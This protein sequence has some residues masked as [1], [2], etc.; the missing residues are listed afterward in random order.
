MCKSNRFPRSA[1]DHVAGEVHQALSALVKEAN[2]HASPVRADSEGGSVLGRRCLRIIQTYLDVSALVTSPLSYQLMRDVRFST[3]TPTRF[4]CLLSQF[5]SPCVSSPENEDLVEEIQENTSQQTNKTMS[6]QFVSNAL[7]VSDCAQELLLTPNS[8]KSIEVVPS[9]TIAQPRAGFEKK[10][11]KSV[12][13]EI[14]ISRTAFSD[15]ENTN[16]NGKK[17]HGKRCAE[18]ISEQENIDTIAIPKNGK[19]LKLKESDPITDD[20]SV[21]IA[22]KTMESPKSSKRSKIK[23][24]KSCRRRLLPQV[25]GQSK[26]T[27]FFKM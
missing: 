6:Q 4:P 21:I 14:S 2:K 5:K 27:G 24:D 18:T 26:L 12:D 11:E 9:K 23:S 1:V 16:A 3:Q 22:K 19:K 13:D 7:V 10:T 17:G 25:K 15:I 8:L 20:K